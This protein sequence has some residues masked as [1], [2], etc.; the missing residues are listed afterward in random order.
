[1]YDS[2]KKG[3]SFDE[4][5][6]T[7]LRM[8]SFSEETSELNEKSLVIAMTVNDELINIGY[9]LS[10]KDIIK[11]SKSKSLY[12]FFKHIKNLIGD[13]KAPPMYP[14]FPKQVMKLSTAQFRFHQMLHYM[15]TYGM[16]EMMCTPVEKGWLPNPDKK[17]KPKKNLRML[18]SKVIGLVPEDEKYAFKSS[19][20]S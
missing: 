20:K 6:F 2:I 15:S 4:L 5:M 7:E 9:T 3:I 11:L 19:Q 10:P 8:I 17:E 1:M 16:E 18:E 13:V 14:D 12:N